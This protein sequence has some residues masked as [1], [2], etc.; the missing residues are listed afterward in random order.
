M[1]GVVQ[2]DNEAGKEYSRRIADLSKE[3]RPRE[4]ALTHG[5]ET[6]STAELIA[7]LLGSGSPGESV[8]DLAQRI[9]HESDNRLST[10]ARRSI[11]GLVK[12]FKGIGTAK[13]VTLL[14]AI[15]LGK[16]FR[17]EE[18]IAPPLIN[19]PVRAYDLMR[20]QLSSLDHEE[21]W[22]IY[23]NN[24]KRVISKRRISQ[25]G[26]TATVT[27]TKI[28]LK[29]GIETLA[30]AII[31]VHNHPSGALRP[32]RQDDEQTERIS[33]AARLVDIAVVDHII[34]AANGFY[35]YAAEG[36]L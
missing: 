14:A 23:L 18:I 10:L 4:K 6:L 13:A 36:R 28:I 33:K 30:T 5:M 34:I 8:I 21:F 24:A 7:I 25:G 32:S 12:S 1:E 2:T 35:S 31:L 17:E 27:D 22:A 20:F 26:I 29:Y 19:D 3:D 11:T 16:R 9:L 15:E